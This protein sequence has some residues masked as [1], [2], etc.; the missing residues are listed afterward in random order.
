MLI[1]YNFVNFKPLIFDNRTNGNDFGGDGDNKK[2]C[3]WN[4]SIKKRCVFFIVILQQHIADKV[5]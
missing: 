4:R 2:L 5:I 1:L 3:L